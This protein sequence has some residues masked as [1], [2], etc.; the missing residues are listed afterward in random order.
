M[1]IVPRT[2][3]GDAQKQWEDTVLQ[4]QLK[5]SPER[6]PAFANSSDIEIQLLYTPED[7]EDWAYEKS[8]GFPGELPYT[9]GPQATMYRARPWTMR[10][11]SGFGSAADTNKRYHYLLAQGQT[12]LSVAYHLPTLLGFDSDNPKSR[13]E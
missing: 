3:I 12:G 11:F 4:P 2:R 10:M 8:L 6:K 13:G 5:R 7:L 9:R 1:A